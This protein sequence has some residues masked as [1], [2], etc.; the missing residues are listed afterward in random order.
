[1]PQD[2]LRHVQ[3]FL[4]HHVQARCQDSALRYYGSGSDVES[5]TAPQVGGNPDWVRH[6]RLP[7]EHG[8]RRAAPAAGLPDHLQHQDVPC[9]NRWGCSPQSHQSYGLQE[10][11]DTDGEALA[12]TPIL[13]SGTS[14]GYAMW[15]HIPPGHI[16][17]GRELP[18]GERPVRCCVGQPPV[19]RHPG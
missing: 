6:L 9:L 12:A 2:A 7:Q 4:G 1:V 8:Q 5:S 16:Q 11:A 3:R 19:Q 13:R 18:H 17:D 14:V 15:L 10:A